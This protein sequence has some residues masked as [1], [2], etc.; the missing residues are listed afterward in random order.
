VVL[1]IA[2]NNNETLDTVTQF[3]Q[4]EGY[5][6]RVLYDASGDVRNLYGISTLPTTFF[7]DKKGII[8]KIQVGSFQNQDS[9]ETILSAMQ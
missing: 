7:I 9:I 8:Q 2:D 5:T 3:I 4:D 1:A 6:F